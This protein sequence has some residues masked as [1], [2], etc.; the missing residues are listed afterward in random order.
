MLDPGSGLGGSGEALQGGRPPPKDPDFYLDW[1]KSNTKESLKIANTF[2]S[3]VLG[4]SSSLLGGTIALWKALDIQ[5]SFKVLMVVL[6]AVCA[7]VSLFSFT[8]IEGDV[9]LKSASD[10]RDLM[11]EVYAAKSRRIVV[12]KWCFAGAVSAATIGLLIGDSKP[13][14]ALWS[15]LRVW[16]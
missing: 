15:W 16:R 4:L 13:L 14:D 5:W 6:W 10:A 11:E 8:P 12:V 3:Q 1:A 7:C 9:D 2:L